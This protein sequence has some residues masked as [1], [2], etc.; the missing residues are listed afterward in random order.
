MKASPSVWTGR[1]LSGLFVLFMLA[2]SIAPKFLMADMVAEQNMT[3]LGWPAKY[4]MLIGLIELACVIL[5]GIPRTSLL[6]AVL[7]TGLLGGAIAANLRVE[8]PL[9]SHTLFGVYLGLFMWGGLWLR[10]ASLRA[11][12]P[13]RRA[14]A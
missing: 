7:M 9:F 6:G 14:A 3:P 10:D 8:N 12:F 1:V 5:Y 4:L 13:F 2:A 11:I